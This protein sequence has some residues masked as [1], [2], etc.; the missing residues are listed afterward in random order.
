MRVCTEPAVYRGRRHRQAPFPLAVRPRGPTV[1]GARSGDIFSP[2]AEKHSK[3]RK[4]PRPVSEAW[5]WDC[6][7]FGPVYPL[8]SVMLRAVRPRVSSQARV[9]V[10]DSWVYGHIFFV[11]PFLRSRLVWWLDGISCRHPSGWSLPKLLL[12]LSRQANGMFGRSICYQ[13]DLFF[14]GHTYAASCCRLCSP[15]R[16]SAP[17]W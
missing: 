2:F 10:Q 13:T 8:L 11:A 17:A 3:M 16:A 6:Q 4:Q 7:L 12:Y 5:T 9:A 1:N 14:F 15:F